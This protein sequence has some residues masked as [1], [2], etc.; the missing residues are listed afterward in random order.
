VKLIIPIFFDSALFFLIVHIYKERKDWIGLD[1]I[2]GADSVLV[3]HYGK[4]S[5]PTSERCKRG[6][7]RVMGGKWAGSGRQ[8]LPL[9]SFP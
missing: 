5:R 1:R 9:N 2:R 6:E 3:L 8:N 4:I 7:E